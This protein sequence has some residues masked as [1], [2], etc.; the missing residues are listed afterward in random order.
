MSMK[1][2]TIKTL[3]RYSR[4]GGLPLL[5]CDY[6]LIKTLVHTFLCTD[7]EILPVPD[8]DVLKKVCHILGIVQTTWNISPM[9][10]GG[11]NNLSQT[12]VKIEMMREISLKE[13]K[14]AVQ[15]T[16]YKFESIVQACIDSAMRIT[17]HVVE[18]QNSE[19]RIL[20]SQMRAQ[21]ESGLALEW[22]MLIDR[23]TH[24]GGPWHCPR[25]YP[26]L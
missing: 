10:S 1:M 18:L 12:L 25:N 9:T 22:Q 24:E 13:Q 17:R 11:T 8:L 2:H 21:D 7:Q 16:V 5:G 6:K 20:M 15:R 23:M 4:N 14:P 19:R 26:R 3:W